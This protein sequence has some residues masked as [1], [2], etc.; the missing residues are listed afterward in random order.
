MAGIGYCRGW[1][2]NNDGPTARQA[3]VAAEAE[4]LTAPE[5]ADAVAKPTRGRR[6]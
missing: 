4:N 5:Q 1:I 2:E 3:E 6:I